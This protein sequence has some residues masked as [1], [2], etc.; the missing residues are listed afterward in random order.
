[1]TDAQPYLF[2]L[3]KPV[4]FKLT[5]SQ[6]L[7]LDWVALN[8]GRSGRWPTRWARKT[9]RTLIRKQLVKCTALS[10]ARYQ[11]TEVGRMV[12]SHMR[13]PRGHLPPAMLVLP[14]EE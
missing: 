2:R 1:M 13:K 14:A 5:I 4:E 6:Y 3:P 10:P 9:L 11:L 8:E 7:A 12:R